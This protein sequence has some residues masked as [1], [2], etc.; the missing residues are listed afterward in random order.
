MFYLLRM[1][2]DVFVVEYV[3]GEVECG[4]GVNVG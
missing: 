2:D 3:Y 4:G 1:E